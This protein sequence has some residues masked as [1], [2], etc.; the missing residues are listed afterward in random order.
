[1]PLTMRLSEATHLNATRALERLSEQNLWSVIN[2]VNLYNGSSPERYG[3]KLLLENISQGASH[4]AAER[5]DP[6]QCHPRTR[7]AIRAEI[8]EWIQA[9]NAMRKLILWIY[10]PAGSGKT[11][12]LQTI[13]ET[14]KEQG[15][16]GASFFFG[17]TAAGRHDASRFVATIACQLYQSIPEIR[18]RIDLAI[19]E[20]PTIFSRALAVQMQVL[21]VE[22][23]KSLQPSPTPIVVITDGLDECGPSRE[24]PAHL[25][26]A[27]GSAI[28]ELQHI[29]LLFVIASRPEFDIREAFSGDLLSS[30]VKSLVLDDKYKPDEDIKLYLDDMFEEIH[31]QWLQLG[32]PLPAVWPAKEDVDFL[33]SKASGQFIFAAAVKRF[34]KSPRHHPQARLRVF[35]GLSA[36][37]TETPFALLDALYLSILS[38]AAD[39]QKLLEIF[40]V[41]FFFDKTAAGVTLTVKGIEALLGFTIGTVLLDMH[42]LVCVP[43]DRGSELRIYH[44]SLYDFF[45]DRSRSGMYYIDASLVDI[46]L[47]RYCLR[48]IANY[49]HIPAPLSL[50]GCV[51]GFLRHSNNLSTRSSEIEGYFASFSLRKVL[52]EIRGYKDLHHTAWDDFLDYIEKN[53]GTQF[54]VFPRIRNEFDAF[55]FERLS[56]YPQALQAVIPA[57]FVHNWNMNKQSFGLCVFHI[58]LYDMYPSKAQHG[59]SCGSDTTLLDI[60]HSGSCDREDFRGYGSVFPTLFNNRSRAGQFYVDGRSWLELAKQIFQIIYPMPTSKYR[61]KFFRGDT[62]TDVFGGVD[63]DQAR[64]TIHISIDQLAKW[65]YRMIGD[66]SEDLEFAVLLRE[67]TLQYDDDGEFG[68]E[69]LTVAESSLIYIEVWDTL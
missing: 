1:M 14:C 5:G 33:V 36:P 60:C 45:T 49:P 23:L 9:P 38:S 44:A 6:P 30:L 27:L 62:H 66:A 64:P 68:E 21:V 43:L 58:S 47:S 12:I 10:G 56:R 61:V 46:T 42:A 24:S 17:R 48:L 57:I 25:L 28:S 52:D 59:Q 2:H 32:G 16:L 65:F 13:A 31:T 39:I 40:T 55:I 34:V 50:A 29:P 67:R 4:D 19:E 18:E 54:D 8:M 63:S 69:L 41:V 51:Q 20:K 53:A 22:P 37:E 15:L 26:S 7:T 35:M 3:L 11:S